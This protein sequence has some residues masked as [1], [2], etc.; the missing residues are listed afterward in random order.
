MVSFSNA[1]INALSVINV[2][3]TWERLSFLASSPFIILSFEGNC[4]N[5][6]NVLSYCLLITPSEYTAIFDNA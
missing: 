1:G 5:I 3:I 6:S 4:V 2:N